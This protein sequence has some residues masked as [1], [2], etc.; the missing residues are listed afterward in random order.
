MHA[1]RPKELCTKV[2]ILVKNSPWVQWGT[3]VR[4]FGNTQWVISWA[5]RIGWVLGGTGTD[6]PD[7]VSR[8]QQWSSEYCK[9]EGWWAPRGPTEKEVLV[10]SQLPQ[11]AQR[12]W[13]RTNLHSVTKWLSPVVCHSSSYRLETTGIFPKSRYACSVQAVI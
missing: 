7:P 5:L 11:G 9:L 13:L 6:S 10:Q 2:Y 12:A 3:P 1:H 8:F 4:W